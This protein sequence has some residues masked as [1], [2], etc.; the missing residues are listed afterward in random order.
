MV[1]QYRLIVLE[2]L[3]VK[4]LARTRL[5]GSVLDA[6]WGELRRQVT[7]KAEATGTKVL[8]ADR[9]YPST[10]LCSGC[11]VLKDM[12]LSE[13]TYR[14]DCGL[15]LDRDV[16]AARNLL[17]IGLREEATPGGLPGVTL[18]EA[19]ASLPTGRPGGKPGRRS[20]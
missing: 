10:K 4:G 6:G 19:G 9:F 2:D 20:E 18:V 11:G 13:R 3:S 7:Y 16:N 12:P 1:R 15:V 14:C 5:S 8:L 17:D